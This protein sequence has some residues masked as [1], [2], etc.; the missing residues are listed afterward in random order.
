MCIRDSRTALYFYSHLLTEGHCMFMYYAYTTV[1]TYVMPRWRVGPKE[2][3]TCNI[4]VYSVHSLCP[5]VEGYLNTCFMITLENFCSFRPIHSLW[6]FTAE[7]TACKVS[8]LRWI[9]IDFGSLF[10]YDHL[11]YACPRRA[12]IYVG[13]RCMSDVCM[14]SNAYLKH[15]KYVH[16]CDY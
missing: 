8:K 5:H 1:D 11:Y 9:S 7:V 12:S 14:H 16:A 13:L 4:A 6:T 2:K 15:Y 3:K 10:V